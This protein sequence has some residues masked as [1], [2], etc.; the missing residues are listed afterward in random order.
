M[1]SD[2]LVETGEPDLWRALASPWRRQLLDLL[3]ARPRT[4]GDLAAQLPALSRFAVM[5]HLSV[6]VAAELVLVER[7]GRER[8]NSLNPVPLRR[9]YERWVTPLADSSAH[10]L[11]AVQRVAERKDDRTMTG[12]ETEEIRAVHITCELT[13]DASAD[14]VFQVIAHESGTWFPFSYGG[15]R[16]TRIVVEPHVGGRHY[17]EWDGGESGYLYG[18]V[19]VYDPPRR[20]AL[21]GRVMPG[22]I[23]DTDYEFAETE[24]GVTVRMTKVAMGPMTEDEAASVRE[25][26]DVSRF[27]DAIRQAA[28]A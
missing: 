16:T 12:V 14:R 27:A 4:T 5:Q 18:H 15:D 7:R 21:R 11:L 25:Y 26:G 20:F 8:V 3:R 19:T 22:T 17:E 13:V 6:L 9:W 2:A 23:L 1:C 28:K 10:E 24:A